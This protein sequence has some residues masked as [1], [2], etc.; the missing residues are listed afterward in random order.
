MNK[1]LIISVT[2][3][4]LSVGVLA[5]AAGMMYKQKVN[6][7]EPPAPPQTVFYSPVITLPQLP[8]KLEFAGEPVPMKNF[9]VRERLDREIIVT[10][11]RHGP[12]ILAYKRANRWFPDIEEVLKKNN[13]PDDFKYMA[14]AESELSEVVSPAGA[15]GYWQFME[16]TAKRYGLTVNDEIDE[17]YHIIKSTEAA[18][19]YLRNSYSRFN[20][21]TMAAASYNVGVP[22]LSSFIEKQRRADFYNLHMNQETSHF[23][24]RIL[25]FKLIFSNPETF[26]IEFRESDLYKPLKFYEVEVSGTVDSWVDFAEA[27][28]ISYKA[29]RYFNPWIRAASLKNKAKNTFYVRIPVNKNLEI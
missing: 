24:F 10:T 26:G 23:I 19:S 7:Q 9:E 5:L 21:W 1:K 6:A 16:E 22:N 13:I 18:C 27:E 28:G 17:R 20:S 12:T 3:I 15:A 11:F 2:I 8:D 14:L 4:V 29:L 25:S